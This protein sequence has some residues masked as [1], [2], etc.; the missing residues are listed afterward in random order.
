MKYTI[1]T[2]DTGKC[3]FFI[4]IDGVLIWQEVNTDVAFFREDNPGH[5]RIIEGTMEKLNLWHCHGHY[6]VI[7]TARPETARKYTERQLFDLGIVYNQLVMGV[8][9]GVRVLINNT[10]IHYDTS[11]ETAQGITLPLNEGISGIELE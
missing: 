5:R 7:T 9:Q 1:K 3:T 2:G 8:G 6:I 4:D 10:S 11:V